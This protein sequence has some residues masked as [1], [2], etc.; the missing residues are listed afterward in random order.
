M[1]KVKFIYLFLLLSYE[2]FPQEVT[3]SS[4]FWNLTSLSGEMKIKGLYRELEGV[5]NSI[6]NSQHSSHF[7][8]GVL[9]R[10]KSYFWHPN[11]L[12]LDVDAEYNPETR[13]EL[14]LIIPDRSETRTLK[15]LDL[16]TTLFMQKSITLSAFINYNQNYFNRENLTNMESNSKQWG[17]VLSYKNKIFP[18]TVNYL[19][20]KWDQKEIQTGRIFKIEQ[21]NFQSK[22]TKSFATR[23]KHELSFSRDEYLRQDAN[24]YQVRNTIDNIYLNNDIFFD[25]KKNHYFKS[26]ISNINQKGE[27]NFKRFQTFE[28]L[29]FKLPN[30]FDFTTNYSFVNIEQISQKSNQS[31]VKCD[32]R[33]KLYSSFNSGIFYEYSNRNHT[34]YNESNNKA[35]FNFFYCKKIPL[36]GKLSLSYKYFRHY[37]HTNS[38]PAL[39]QVINEE[40]V[41]TD[42]QVV[43]L[44][45]AYINPETVVVKDVTGTIIYQLDFDYILIERSNYVEIQR[46]P[47]GQIANEAIVYVDYTA[48]QPGSYQYNTNNQFFSAKVLL[49]GQ[50]IEFY[51]RT[52]RQDYINIVQ[53]EYL[54]LNY[55]S[56]NVYGSR[57]VFGFASGGI[58][59]DNY[60]SN[61]IPYQMI[62]Y[63]INFQK[64]YKNK[65]LV[66]LNGNMRYYQMINE[67]IKQKYSDISGRIAYNIKSHTKLNLEIGYRNQ[68]GQGIDLD[69][70]T[71]RSEF[72]TIVRQMFFTVGLEIY[73]RNYLGEQFDLNG[74][75]FQV[76]RKF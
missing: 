1:K 58:E 6:Y 28:N 43:L 47:G 26:I 56:Q 37:H 23:D 10:T 52:S 51:F 33:H 46:F 5:T 22:I 11:F 8:G 15:K 2:C 73:R 62:R 30:N 74:A 38:D 64:K 57:I 59:F 68:K 76:A 65:L 35:G 3:T 4:K 66:S 53:T 29:S 12:L 36:N 17:S 49:F 13:Q 60:K 9:L 42:G 34:L 69:L 71:A 27:F 24:S 21:N 55:F 19:Q 40:H 44:N 75:Y 31:R 45:K 61:I 72:T 67:E 63:Y 25:S 39:L 14:Y 50:L 18:L 32:I 16:R 41:L 7:S 48:T 54:T 20:R 70:F